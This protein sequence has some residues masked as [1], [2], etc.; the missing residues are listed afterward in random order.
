MLRRI[1]S[2]VVCG[3]ISISATIAV[4]QQLT[5]AQYKAIM[6]T[7]AQ[8]DARMNKNGAY[9]N[10]TNPHKAMAICIDWSKVQGDKIPDSPTMTNAGDDL[11]S[12]KKGTMD[13]CVSIEKSYDCK[14]L[15]VDVDGRMAR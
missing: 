6:A 12:V 11:A 1:M 2:V 7:K 15:L 13:S 9:A 14:C 5:D 3:T 10:L 8:W 4:A